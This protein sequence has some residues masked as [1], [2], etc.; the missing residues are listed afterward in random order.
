MFCTPVPAGRTITAERLLANPWYL[1]GLRRSRDPGHSPTEPTTYIIIN[2]D[3][4][5]IPIAELN[6]L[7]AQQRS[8][9]GLC[10]WLI[11]TACRS[12]VSSCANF[13]A[14]GAAFGGGAERR[15]HRASHCLC[16]MIFCF[17]RRATAVPWTQDCGLYPL[18]GDAAV[19]P[20]V[21]SILEPLFHRET[22]LCKLTDFDLRAIWRQAA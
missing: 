9:A 14:A 8:P 18:C 20:R 17:S 10:P 13:G 3:V 22:L 4:W 1:N 19:T 5:A 15:C 21:C 2:L 12:H 7:S 11:F 16:P 6:I